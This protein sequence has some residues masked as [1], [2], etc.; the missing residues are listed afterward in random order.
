M[1]DDVVRKVAGSVT[2][3]VHFYAV[4]CLLLVVLHMAYVK[5]NPAGHLR[6]VTI[7]AIAKG[8]VQ[9]LTIMV[10]I[11]S[12]ILFLHLSNTPQGKNNTPFTFVQNSRRWPLALW[13]PQH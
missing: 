2:S 6:R 5:Q 8:I 1:I 12:A 9:P 13:Q 11:F 4:R 7:C 10:R 3:I